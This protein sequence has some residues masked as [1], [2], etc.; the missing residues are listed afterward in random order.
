MFSSLNCKG[1]F[2]KFRS[3]VKFFFPAFAFSLVF[4]R[5]VRNRDGLSLTLVVNSLKT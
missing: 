3:I 5:D 1:G 2:H 4:N